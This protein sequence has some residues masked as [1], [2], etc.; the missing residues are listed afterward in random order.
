MFNQNT[1]EIIESSGWELLFK[2]YDDDGS[3]TFHFLNY[4]LNR[5]NIMQTDFVIADRFA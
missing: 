1:S 2:A 4:D 3:G 5:P